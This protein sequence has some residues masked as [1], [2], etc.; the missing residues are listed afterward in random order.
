MFDLMV[1]NNWFLIMHGHVVATNK[2][3]RIF[4]FVF[5]LFAVIIV[6]NVIIAFIL[7]AFQSIFPILNDIYRGHKS[8][9]RVG[10]GFCQ[11]LFFF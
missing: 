3:A 6:S 7:D 1:V 8:F 2:S 10:D 5:Y 4:F 11:D 9:E